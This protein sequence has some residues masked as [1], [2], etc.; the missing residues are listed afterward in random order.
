M[1]KDK[2]RK[3][4]YRRGVYRRLES[5]VGKW[6]GEETGREV[7]REGEEVYVYSTS[8]VAPE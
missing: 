3:G 1:G 4:V 5:R 7:R 8:P 6:Y 2:G